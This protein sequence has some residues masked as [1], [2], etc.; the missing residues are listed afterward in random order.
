MEPFDDETCRLVYASHHSFTF[1]H[2]TLLFPKDEDDNVEHKPPPPV[3]NQRQ[4]L[5]DLQLQLLHCYTNSEFDE[6]H[7]EIWPSTA[8]NI[9]SLLELNI[10]C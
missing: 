9:K 7:F 5:V 3:Y 1:L 2:F 10:L 6:N 4:S 8:D